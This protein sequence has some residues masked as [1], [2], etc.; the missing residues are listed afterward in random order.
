M[1]REVHTHYIAQKCL[2]LC[3]LV[4]AKTCIGKIDGFFS[5][6]VF[7]IWPDGVWKWGF[8]EGLGRGLGTEALAVYTSKTLY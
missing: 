7:E 4:P 6:R 5:S 8:G 3:V 2:F 1:M